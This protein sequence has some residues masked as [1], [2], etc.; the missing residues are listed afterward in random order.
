MFNPILH[1]EVR[2]KILAK[3]ISEDKLSFNELKNVLSLSDGNLSAHI[4]KLENA[5][6]IDILKNSRTKNQKL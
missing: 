3:L 5:G 1:Q 2:A 4:S 6:Y